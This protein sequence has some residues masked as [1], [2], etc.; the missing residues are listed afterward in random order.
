MHKVA[1][2]YISGKITPEHF[3]LTLRKATLMANMTDVIGN[4][5]IK[6]YYFLR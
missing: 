1:G 3:F 5:K 4:M 2:A 6:L